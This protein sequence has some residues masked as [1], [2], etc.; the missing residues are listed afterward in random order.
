MCTLAHILANYPARASTS[1]MQELDPV[2]RDNGWDT[3]VLA[4]APGGGSQYAP[5]DELVKRPSARSTQGGNPQKGGAGL[6]LT[7]L[8]NEAE[9][10]T[11]NPTLG[12]A[13]E[14]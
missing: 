5:P 10:D 9:H 11:L 3:F 14:K 8:A 13:W 2:G 6:S 7:R 12:C 4:R 1:L